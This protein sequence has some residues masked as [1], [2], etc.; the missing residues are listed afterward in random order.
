MTF[1][2]HS[3]KD[4]Y[5]LFQ[6]V[7]CLSD[8]KP[9]GYEALLR[10]RT[11]RQPEQL[12]QHA[13]RQK[14]LF[15]LDTLS[16]RNAISFF[17]HTAEYRE[18]SEMLFL[19]VFPSTIAKKFF[20]KICGE[21]ATKY[22]EVANRIVFEINESMS[23]I[24]EWNNEVF[25]QNVSNLRKSGFR[26][27]FDDVGEGATTLKKIVELSPDFIK[28]DRF[29][30]KQ[31]AANKQKQKMV[32]FFVHYCSDETRLILEGLEDA[33]DVKV[34]KHLGVKFGQGYWLAKPGPLP[35]PP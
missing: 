16:I 11:I 14:L 31:L 9:L 28:M 18:T 10:S 26:I 13:I 33:N 24:G 27:A 8:H 2:F 35:G 6:P 17:F 15:E 3:H 1:S 34:A 7:F 23:E 4:L 5:H 32:K 25:A 30:G 12:F 29:F 19:N 22:N 20:T 21:I